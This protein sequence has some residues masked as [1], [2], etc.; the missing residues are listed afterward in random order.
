M[1]SENKIDFK[2]QYKLS[3]D[4]KHVR[5]F[6]R[7][8]TAIYVVYLAF[9][10]FGFYEFFISIFLWYSKYPLKGFVVLILESLILLVLSYS[11]WK[12][13]SFYRENG[14]LKCPNVP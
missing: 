14:P 5:N 7:F 13:W 8:W 6:L 9:N 1:D 12:M 3:T 4:Q 11:I 10:V 2:S